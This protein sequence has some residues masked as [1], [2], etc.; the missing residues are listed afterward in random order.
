MVVFMIIGA[1]QEPIYELELP[2]KSTET[3]SSSTAED[4]QYLDQFVLYSS[5]DVIS[6]LMWTN[7]ST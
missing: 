7:S 1:N 5:L 6:S 4:G 2:V 3:G